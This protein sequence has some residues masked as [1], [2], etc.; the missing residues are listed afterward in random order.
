MPE[1]TNP[2]VQGEPLKQTI[3]T[4]QSSFNNTITPYAVTKTIADLFEEQA[5]AT[6][7]NIALRWR[8][9]ETTYK[10]LNAQANQLANYLIAGGV[11]NNDT[12]GVLV[13]R[14]PDLVIALLAILKA[15]GTYVP[16]DP[17]YPVDRQEY[18]VKNSAIKIVL[19]N[20]EQQ[21]GSIHDNIRV[22]QLGEQ[23]QAGFS[24]ENPNVEIDSHQLAYIIY[25]SGS[26][27]NPKGVMIEHHSVVNL[28]QW[29]NTEFKIGV[30]DKLLFITSICFD[31]SVYDI[32]G[33]L[34]SGGSV[35]IA[36]KEETMNISS[37]A[38]M[39]KEHKATFWDSVPSTLD[40]LVRGLEANAR[41]YVQTELRV[42]FL[43]GDWIPVNLPD[44]IKRFFPNA[45]VI[46][47]GGATEATV[48]SNFY[49]IDKVEPKWKSIPYGRPIANNFFYILDR[50]LQPVQAGE[51]G[52]LY[53]GGVG[54]AR[55]YANDPAK[56][57]YSF[58]PD[59]FNPD[60]GGQMY[61]TGD[62]GRMMPDGN[63]EFLG[64]I[65]QQVKIRGFRVELGEI[66]SV[67]KEYEFVD[68][69]LVL[70]KD[71]NGSK[72]LIGYV[73][74]K[75]GYD[76]D[77]LILFLKRKLPDY[78]VPAIWI[79]LGALPLNPNGKIDR[80]ALPDVHDFQL[81]K[82][83]MAARNDAEAALADIWKHV[84]EIDEVGMLD[85]FF[86]LGGQ[87]LIAVQLITEVGEKF[88]KKLNLN[89]IFKYPTIE[90]LAEFLTGEKAKDSYKSLVPVKATGTK[91]PLYIIHGDGYNISN[92]INLANN[93]DEDQPLFSL[94][95]LGLDGKD[96]PFDR[97]EDI[98]AHYVSEILHHNPLGPYAIVGYSFGGYVAIEMKR[99][100][101]SMGKEI[102]TLGVF[103]TDAGVL[104][105]KRGGLNKLPKKLLRQFPKALFVIKSLLNTPREAIN[106]QSELAIKK[107]KKLRSKFR[108]QEEKLTGIG[109]NLCKI[110]SS[111]L[112]AL[113]NYDLK[114]FQ[115][116]LHLFKA[117]NRMYF[118]DDLAFLGWKKFANEGITVYDIPGDH[119][120]MFC[121]P[122]V[123]ELATMLQSILKD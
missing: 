98:A 22:I 94:Q 47:L 91:T 28:V 2:N 48:W 122:H 107:W 103:D 54:V 83:R 43:S 66:E 75:S 70:A 41:N 56:T 85:N 82:S 51:Q 32:F 99:Q 30:E 23:P 20:I 61:R 102:K 88:K 45:K 8:N 10:E 49:A 120:T 17:E 37:L 18:I 26:T 110:N 44:R 109:L 25:T 112:V 13:T 76:R 50:R 92:F 6:P 57:D 21:L 33:I 115:G 117:K 31:L 9:K 46:S 100:L 108:K 4:L 96:E 74:P 38:V 123:K 3:E 39:L 78:M 7:V 19:T 59:P 27:G 104:Q 40:F 65:D 81:T 118:V 105:Y 68:Y 73:V 55:A 116:K 5:V 84:L 97:L 35:I 69:A 64:R 114:P 42:V 58:M 53:I 62:M 24:A 119:Q 14:S 29:V 79:E 63:M 95:P 16:I 36:E 113:K 121:T 89:S 77:A 93:L 71:M 111:H 72:R 101:E 15:G 11:K 1:T 80:N 34:S 90:L 87:S 60:C 106:Y 86:D 52:E 67:A 12:V